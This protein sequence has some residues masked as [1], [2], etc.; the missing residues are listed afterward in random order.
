M[1]KKPTTP[2]WLEKARAYAFET[3]QERFGEPPNWLK[4]DYVTLSRLLVLKSGSITLEDFKARWDRFLYAN[5]KFYRE[6]RWALGFFCSQ[7]DSFAG[8]RAKRTLS[9]AELVKNYRELEDRV[10]EIIKANG[11][12]DTPEERERLRPLVRRAG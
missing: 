12:P 8:V 3:W 11:F 6:N 4:K 7:F 9:Q 5:K 2:D 10:S 1:K